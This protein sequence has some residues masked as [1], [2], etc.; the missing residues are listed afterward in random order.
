MASLDDGVKQIG[1][2]ERY[3]RERNENA[4]ELEAQLCR[5]TTD[6]IAMATSAS[7][8]RGGTAAAH[9]PRSRYFNSGH[10]ERPE[11]GHDGGNVHDENVH[12]SDSSLVR[13]LS[14]LSQAVES[15]C[16]HH[17]TELR[18]WEDAWS[19]MCALISEA[20]QATASATH[21]FRHDMDMMRKRYGISV[22]REREKS[23]SGNDKHT[24]EPTA[25]RHRIGESSS[26][27]VV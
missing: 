22:H 13:L 14:C 8:S 12:G 17:A 18:M 7:T 3:V 27:H 6:I 24:C 26:S 19:K 2:G 20:I 10:D 11:A 25:C 21:S 15:S 5:R 23:G 16:V 9:V 1:D 4:A